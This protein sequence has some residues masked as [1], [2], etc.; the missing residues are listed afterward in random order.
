MDFASVDREVD[1]LENFPF[2][3]LGVQIFDFE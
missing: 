3:N 1:T 2:A